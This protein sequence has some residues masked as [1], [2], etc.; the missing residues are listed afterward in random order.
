MYPRLRRILFRLDPECAH[1]LS[2]KALR[3]AGNFPLSNWFFTQLYKTESKPVHVFGLAFKNP[4]GL[5][6]G[7]D[8]DALAINGLSALGF[9]HLEVGTV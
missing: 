1:Q 2:L 4:V 6:A 9:G 5:A 3:L 7:Y 8:K